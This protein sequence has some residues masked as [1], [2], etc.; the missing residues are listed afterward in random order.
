MF[1]HDVFL[2]E[3][4]QVSNFF[5]GLLDP[6]VSWR[7]RG[8]IGVVLKTPAQAVGFKSMVMRIG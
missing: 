2:P 3:N 1:F 7:T 5:W 6:I 8:P 4:F